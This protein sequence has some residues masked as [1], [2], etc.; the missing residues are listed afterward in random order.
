MNLTYNCKSI[1]FPEVEH[2]IPV[3][4]LLLQRNCCMPHKCNMRNNFPS[5]PD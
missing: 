3:A 1:Y 5:R 4:T 2:N